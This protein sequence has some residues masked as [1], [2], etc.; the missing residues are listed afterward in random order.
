MHGETIRFR[1]GAPSQRDLLH[2]C[3]RRSITASLFRDETGKYALDASFTGKRPGRQGRYGACVTE[4]GKDDLPFFMDGGE[5]CFFGSGG[6]AAFFRA[7][8]RHDVCVACVPACAKRFSWCSAA[9][10]DDEPRFSGNAFL[11]PLTSSML[12]ERLDSIHASLVSAH[13]ARIRRCHGSVF[14]KL[15][16]TGCFLRLKGAKKSDGS[17]QRMKRRKRRRKRRFVG[18]EE[19]AALPPE[20][21][22]S[23]NRFCL[24]CLAE[25]ETVHR[26][27]KNPPRCAPGVFGPGASAGRGS[28]P[29]RGDCARACGP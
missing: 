2:R 21:E 7:W 1:L 25:P 27:R 20:R 4:Q 18:D 26:I 17:G 9:A 23:Q 14:G 11:C 5:R 10:C 22:M 13:R 8:E 15:R 19:E 3:F 29:R 12:R 6:G 24:F 28:R 16:T